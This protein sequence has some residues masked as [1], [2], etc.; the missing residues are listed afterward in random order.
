MSKLCSINPAQFLALENVD[1]IR[2]SG[3]KTDATTAFRIGVK[4][5]DSPVL[6]ISLRIRS[7]IRRVEDLFY[8]GRK[9]YISRSSASRGEAETISY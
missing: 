4:S 5:F 2:I 9:V 3:Q 6:R 8:D 1:G 7:T